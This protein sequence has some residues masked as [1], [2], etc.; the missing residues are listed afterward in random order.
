MKNDTRD[1]NKY[2]AADTIADYLTDYAMDLREQ[3]FYLDKDQLE[4]AKNE[5][6]SAV[7][8]SRRIF[9]GGN[10]GSAAISEHLSCDVQKGCHTEDYKPQ[11]ISMTSNTALLTAIANDLS[12]TKIF[13]YQFDSYCLSSDELVIL[14][15]SSGNSPN[16]ISAVKWAQTVGSKVIGL[17]GFDGGFLK[18][19]ADISLHVPANNYGIV[20]DSHQ[21]I[22]HILAQYCY[23]ALKN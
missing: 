20:E 13:S 10:G 12:Y 1:K 3:L 22:M 4:L 5:L 6:L 15:S 17:T 21:A 16:I 18:E 11:V 9:V 19:Y 14:I 7:R 2:F 23:L 8:D